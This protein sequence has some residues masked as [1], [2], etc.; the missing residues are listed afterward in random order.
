MAAPEISLSQQAIAIEQGAAFALRLVAPGATSW[1]ASGLPDG[2]TIDTSTGEISG[3]PTTIQEKVALITATNADGSS[4]PAQLALGIVA[5]SGSPAS[6]D[7][8]LNMDAETGKVTRVGGDAAEVIYLGSVGDLRPV[9]LGV[10]RDGVLQPVGPTG[11][12]L[13]VWQNRDES[14]A[15]LNTDTEFVTVGSGTSTRYRIQADLTGSVVTAAADEE[16][17][18]QAQIEWQVPDQVDSSIDPVTA[19]DTFALA[20]LATDYRKTLTFPVAEAGTYQI[21]LETVLASYTFADITIDLRLETS[22]GGLAIASKSSDVVF[23][24]STYSGTTLAISISPLSEQLTYAGGELTLDVDAQMLGADAGTPAPV[25]TGTLSA[26]SVTPATLTMTSRPF[27]V[28]VENQ[29][30]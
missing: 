25:I 12:T 14:P 13:S 28:V 15:D 20:E 3:N 10:T 19:T 26:V 23:V 6:L 9:A 5:P 18:M 21:V 24:A 29:I 30:S 2:L 7:L 17:G 27:T 4:S 1:S 22:G 11:V 8:R 16:S